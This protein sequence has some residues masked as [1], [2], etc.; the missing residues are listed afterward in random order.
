MC[1]S[2]IDGLV[3]KCLKSSNGVMRFIVTHGV[4]VQRMRSLW[5]ETRSSVHLAL[6][7]RWL[8]WLVLITSTKGTTDPEGGAI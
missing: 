6:R 1:Y 7:F 3:V 5:D 2:V 4:Y 8:I